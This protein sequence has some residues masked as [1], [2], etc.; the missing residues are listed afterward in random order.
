MHIKIPRFTLAHRGPL[1]L[2]SAHSLFSGSRRRPSNIFLCLALS[3]LVTDAFSFMA[4][5]P[6]PLTRT[7]TTTKSEVD[8]KIGPGF[9]GWGRDFGLLLPPSLS[10]LPVFALPRRKGRGEIGVQ[11]GEGSVRLFA[12]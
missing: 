5:P 3:S 10:L 2:Q 11:E 1:D 6:N 8:R 9:L 4:A 12:A 7:V